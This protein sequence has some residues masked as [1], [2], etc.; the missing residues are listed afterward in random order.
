MY[1]FNA[2]PHDIWNVFETK[3]VRDMPQRQE[4]KLL[5]MGPLGITEYALRLLQHSR[6]V[7]HLMVD[8]CCVIEEREKYHGL[9]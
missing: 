9:F 2:L 1:V 6:S 7:A 8:F 4:K 5:E 3:S